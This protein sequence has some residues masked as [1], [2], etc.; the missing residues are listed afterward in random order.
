MTM[1]TGGEVLAKCLIEEG[2]KYVFG[3]PGDQLYPLLDSLHTSDGI[4]F[5]TF[6]HEQA[7]AHAHGYIQKTVV[8]RANF[9]NG[10][11]VI[12]GVFTPAVTGHALQHCLPHVARGSFFNCSK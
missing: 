7:A 12:A 2:V 3:V 10:L 11:Q 1:L 6:R 4:E 5:I 9:N 8:D